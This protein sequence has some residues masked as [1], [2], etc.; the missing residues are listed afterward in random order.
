MQ[1][2]NGVTIE[3]LKAQAALADPDQTSAADNGRSE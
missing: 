2:V 3:G 1:Q